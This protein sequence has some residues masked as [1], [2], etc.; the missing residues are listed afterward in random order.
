[1]EEKIGQLVQLNAEYI[2][3]DDSGAVT[4]PRE[5][6]KIGEH[7]VFSIGSLLNFSGADAMRKIQTLYLAHGEKT[8]IPLLFMLDVIHGF[9]TVY[10]IPLAIGASFDPELMRKCAAMA[11]HE[12]SLAGVNVAF[13]PMVDLARDARWGRVMETTGEDPYL[14]SQMGAAVVR[15]YQGDLGAHNVAACAKHFAAYGAAEAGRDYNTVDM[16]RRTLFEFYMSAYRAAAD[17]GVKM[18]MTSFNVFDGIPM[19]ANSDLVEGVLRGEWEFD[20]VVITDYNAVG[21]MITHGYAAD[22]EAA[23]LA[24]IRGGVDIEMMSVTFIKHVKRLIEEGK[25]SQERIDGSVLRVLRLKD[26]LG[27]FGNP[28]RSVD[29]EEFERV[30][31]CAEH[32]AI[33]RE[34]AEKS[35]VLLKNDGVLPFA[36]TLKTVAV[37]GPHAD[38]K[39]LIGSWS[40]DGRITDT[41]T[42]YEG[43]RALL[44]DATVTTAEGCSL[45]LDATDESG[46]ARAV[47]LAA[48]ADAV[49]LCLGEDM[50]DS[51]EGNSK[52]DIELPSIQYKLLNA[53]L[54]ANSNTAVLLFNGR[55][56]A[57]PRLHRDAPAIL[58]MWFPGTEGGAAAANLLFGKTSPSGKLTMSFPYSTG[59]CPIYYNRMNTGRPRGTDARRVA[60]CSSYIDGPND[61]LYPFGYGLTYTEFEYSNIEL[62][63]RTL[64]RGGKITASVKVKNIGKRAGTETVQLYIRDNFA[65]RVRPVKELKGF[66]KVE[67]DAGES[68]TVDFD[69][70]EETLAFYGAQGFAAEAGDFTVFIGGSSDTQNAAFFELTE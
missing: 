14:N 22:D 20:G 41:V 61:P 51:G 52:L 60:Y 44:P 8:R 13:A 47:E 1:M 63:S 40:C 21:E 68:A 28:Y 18:F 27:L 9:R 37:I 55:P 49:V 67:L 42:V 33:A 66:K 30:A 15:G 26:E 39:E 11:A 12:A 16:S 2:L 58:D 69:M 3:G 17:A 48:R 43:I 45:A 10:P 46:F 62:S 34:A 25:I 56:L 64:R 6:M 35:A 57:I 19:T 29:R 5:S 31:C 50:G 65:S 38:N 59:Q 54:N 24:A 32:R 23:A 7:E 4:G 70:T 36:D 53:V